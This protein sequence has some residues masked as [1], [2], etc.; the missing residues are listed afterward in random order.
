MNGCYH[1]EARFQD[2]VFDLKGKEIHAMWHMLCERGQ[3]LKVNFRDIE[4]DDKQ[5]R[6]HWE[7]SYT[8]S[9]TGRIVHNKIE[10]VFEF[11]DEKIIRHIDRF[12]FWKWSTMA[13]GPV[14][15]ALGWSSYLRT[16]VSKKAGRS[17]EAFIHAHPEY[18]SE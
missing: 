11:K 2:E 17:L 10:A 15:A 5:G 9:Q 16:K 7:A 8:F 14:G 12:N 18:E 1:Q 13:L 4:A 6:T 3:D